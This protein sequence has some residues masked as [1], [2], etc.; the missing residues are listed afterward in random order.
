MKNKPFHKP[1][2]LEPRFGR[3][4]Y[5]TTVR[6][7]VLFLVSEWPCAKGGR[8]EFA[9]KIAIDCLNGGKKPYQARNALIQAAEEARI[10]AFAEEYDLLD[11][12]TQ[13]T[14]PK[15]GS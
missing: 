7:A 6:E 1:V 14:R 4:R 3:V 9:L 12:L 2:V 10:H 5:V 15:I 8:H 13:R 11:A